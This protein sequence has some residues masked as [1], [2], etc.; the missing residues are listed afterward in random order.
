METNQV[1]RRWVFRVSWDFS[2]SSSSRLSSQ[3]MSSLP[4]LI[5]QMVNMMSVY[6]F[7]FINIA[8][9]HGYQ[10]QSELPLALTV[11]LLSRG[12]LEVDERGPGLS[13][14]TQVFLF[15]VSTP[16]RARCLNNSRGSYFNF[17]S[18]NYLL[19]YVACQ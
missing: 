19:L 5:A 16:A 1:R 15:L 17:E 13:H 18:D 8:M 10:A 11:K 6:R 14:I 2:F 7:L 4:M 3:H 9:Y 12:C